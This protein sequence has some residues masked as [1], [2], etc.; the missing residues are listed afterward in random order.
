MK[1]PQEQ[2][3][4][5]QKHRLKVLPYLI[6][7]HNTLLQ[8]PGQ[9]VIWSLRTMEQNGEPRNKSTCLQLTD[10]QQKRPKPVLEEGQPLQ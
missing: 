8:E 5:D 3:N 2:S 4:V 10:S 7:R 1:D 9:F 6:S